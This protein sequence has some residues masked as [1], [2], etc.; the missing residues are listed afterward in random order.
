MDDDDDG[1]DNYED[2]LKISNG[3]K[4]LTGNGDDV[5]QCLSFQIVLGSRHS[6]P[7]PG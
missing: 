5:L 2:G 6:K 3:S 4:D 1:G 7:S